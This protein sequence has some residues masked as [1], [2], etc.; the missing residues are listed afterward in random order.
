MKIAGLS[1]RGMVRKNNQDLYA[2]RELDGFTIGVVCD[3]MGGA[4][5]GNKASA[6]AIKKILKNSISQIK[7]KLSSEDVRSVLRSAIRKANA[8]VY[9]K[10]ASYKGYEGMGTTAVGFVYM[11]SKERAFFVNV[12]DSRAYIMRAGE[13]TQITNDHS[14]VYEMVA[15]GHITKEEARIHPNRNIITRAIGTDEE[16]HPDTFEVDI[17]RGDMILLCSDGLTSMMSD[18]EILSILVTGQSV[19]K[20]A[21]ELVNRANMAGGADNVTVLLAVFDSEGR[22]S[23]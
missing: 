18:E 6:L 21:A 16:L 10:A 12:G 14:L 15:K 22:T 20:M 19:E 4:A 8:D 11:N 9:D 2:Y 5:A 13:L 23:A 17:M 1:D 3:G 7:E